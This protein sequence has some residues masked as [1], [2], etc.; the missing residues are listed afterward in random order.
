MNLIE[1]ENHGL[2]SERKRIER[3]LV[4][5]RITATISCFSPS[6]CSIFSFCLSSS[7][8][9]AIKSLYRQTSF[10][11]WLLSKSR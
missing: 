10:C 5:I 3:F 7:A 1:D 2:T 4:L 6:S 8:R 9:A 11:V